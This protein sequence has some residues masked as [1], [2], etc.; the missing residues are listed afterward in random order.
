MYAA[1]TM[2]K[3]GWRLPKWVVGCVCII[4]TTTSRLYRYDFVYSGTYQQRRRRKP[5][6][7]VLSFPPLSPWLYECARG[8]SASL[9]PEHT[10]SRR[11]RARPHPASDHHQGFGY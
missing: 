10:R 2:L 5:F 3:T 6:S 4:T 8:A 1:F 7:P 11:A 9:T